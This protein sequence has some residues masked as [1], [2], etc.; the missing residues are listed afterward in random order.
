MKEN[1]FLLKYRLDEKLRLMKLIRQYEQ[2]DYLE[3]LKNAL[4]KYAEQEGL[5]EVMKEIAQNYTRFGSRTYQMIL[6]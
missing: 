2:E 6:S 1:D 3:G 4:R 5:Q